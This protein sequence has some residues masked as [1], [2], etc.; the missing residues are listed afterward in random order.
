MKVMGY[1]LL[2]AI[3]ICLLI[4]G[5]RYLKVELNGEGDQWVIG[6]YILIGGLYSALAVI[7]TF[8]LI[9]YFIYIPKIK[10]KI[11]LNNTRFFTLFVIIILVA[12]IE[13]FYF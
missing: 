4:I 13:R 11:I 2:W 3:I 12:I 5:L 9:D 10:K 8:L 6:F 7:P 1:I